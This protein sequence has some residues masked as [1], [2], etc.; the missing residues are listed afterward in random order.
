MKTHDEKP[1]VTSLFALVIQAAKETE[2][3]ESK[4]KGPKE[5]EASW[6]KN[7]GKIWRDASGRFGGGPKSKEPATPPTIGERASTAVS[8]ARKSAEK[9]VDSGK[10]EYRKLSNR[11]D[12]ALYD[13]KNAVHDAIKDPNKAAEEVKKALK[14]HVFAPEK[15]PEPQGSFEK[16]KKQ[17]TDTVSSAQKSVDMMLIDSGVKKEYRKAIKKGGEIL[18]SISNMIG[19]FRKDPQGSYKKAKEYIDKKI[20][21]KEEEGGAGAKEF[22][23]AVVALAAGK[24]EE[25]KKLIDDKANQVID[26]VG[27]GPLRDAHAEATKATQKAIS[28]F[29]SKAKPD[30][31]AG[32]VLAGSAAVAVLAHDDLTDEVLTEGNK[33]LHIADPEK[34]EKTIKKLAAKYEAALKASIDPVK[35]EGRQ[36]EMAVAKELADKFSA[37]MMAALEKI[38]KEAEKKKQDAAQAKQQASQANQASPPVK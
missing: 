12:E 9:A 28:E 35:K 19:D 26:S 7:V 24:P 6:L 18:E 1:T 31:F 34:R 8:N 21:P 11:A 38:A 32:A 30:Q 4:P 29:P 10:K 2:S 36:K 37:D 22:A 33:L 14:E 3:K 5:Y 17:V 16:A 15:E 20:H 13:A 27:L 25:V 23:H